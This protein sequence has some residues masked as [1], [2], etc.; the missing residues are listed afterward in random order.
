MI[1]NILKLFLILKKDIN[2]EIFMFYLIRF[3]NESNLLIIII[4]VKNSYF[5]IC[6]FSHSYL[7]F[8]Y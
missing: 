6:K 4:T 7:Y 1:V 5:L 2:H 3:K 8:C